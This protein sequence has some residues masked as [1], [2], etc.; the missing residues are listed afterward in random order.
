MKVAGFLAT[1]GD[2]G[3][4]KAEGRREERREI[5]EIDMVQEFQNFCLLPPA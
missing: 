4:G 2:P 3:R 5:P 1:F